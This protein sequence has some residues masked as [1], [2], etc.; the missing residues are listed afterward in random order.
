MIEQ[1]DLKTGL[2]KQFVIPRVNKQMLHTIPPSVCKLFVI[3][4]VDI[5]YSSTC[6]MDLVDYCIMPSVYKGF[7]IP[8]INK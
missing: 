8:W 1:I 6:S 2:H 3:P 5:L 4:W 7:V